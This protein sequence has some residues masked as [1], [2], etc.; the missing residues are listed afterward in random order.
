MPHTSNMFLKYPGIFD[1]TWSVMVYYQHL[2]QLLKCPIIRSNVLILCC[3][4]GHNAKLPPIHHDVSKLLKWF[5]ARRY[6]YQLCHG[7]TSLNYYQVSWYYQSV[8][9]LLHYI[10]RS[11]TAKLDVRSKVSILFR[12]RA[13]AFYRQWMSEMTVNYW[14]ELVQSEFANNSARQL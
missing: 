8:V 13:L 10:T 9:R 7:H 1:T 3:M 5:E 6:A 2:I 11:A 14:N 4:I 12:R